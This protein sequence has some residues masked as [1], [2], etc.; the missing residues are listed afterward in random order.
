MI[1]LNSGVFTYKDFQVNFSYKI[2]TML[3]KLYTDFKKSY[4][5]RD[6]Y[7]A[8]LLSKHIFDTISSIIIYCGR[9]MT[10]ELQCKIV[11]R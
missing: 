3:Q 7:S 9:L 11:F 10:S 6:Y 4:Y 2:T 5:E 1:H 8:H